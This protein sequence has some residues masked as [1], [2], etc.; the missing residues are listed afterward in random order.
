M[1]YIVVHQVGTLGLSL[2]VRKSATPL[3][4]SPGLQD[5]SV[6]HSDVS[7]IHFAV[8]VRGESF[9]SWYLLYGI[10]LLVVI[11]GCCRHPLASLY[12][13]QITINNP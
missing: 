2:V 1:W 12:N 11:D 9:G 3:E 4:G 10:D 5:S 8:L 13:N 6:A 7:G